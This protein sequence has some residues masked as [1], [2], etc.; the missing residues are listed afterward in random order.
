[1]ISAHHEVIFVHIPKTGGQSITAAF[2]GSLGLEYKHRHILGCFQRPPSWPKH[3]PERLAHLA[4]WEYASLEFF[5]ANLVDR[6]YK[7]TVVREPLERLKSIYR[8]RKVR[9]DFSNWVLHTLKPSGSDRWV[10]P[11]SWWISD[12]KGEKIL[13]D[14]ILRFESL[15][16]D[17][18]DFAREFGVSQLLPHRNISSHPQPLAISDE[19]LDRVAVVYKDDY[20]RFGWSVPGPKV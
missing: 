4:A 7:I 10:K 14:R 15:Q 19:A 16:S 20:E 9:E 12:A 8:Y 13:V 6:Y 1:M 5:P 17:W 2:C 3:F 11:Q 18:S